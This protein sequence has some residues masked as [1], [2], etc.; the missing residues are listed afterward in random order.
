MNYFAYGSNLDMVQMAQRCPGAKLVGTAQLTGHRLCFPRRSPVRGCAVAS[1]E[2]HADEIVWGAI[3]DMS[4]DDFTRL[5]AREGYDPV[6]P[7]AINRYLRIDVS[8]QQT[9]GQTAKAITYVAVPDDTN[10]RPSAEYMRHIIEGAIVHGFPD[11]YIKMLRAI[12]TAED[13][14]PEAAA[15]RVAEQDEQSET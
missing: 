15:P 5:D 12:E 4:E 6:N 3:Y 14:Q 13:D 1:V 7:T 2:A 11:E 10:G 8:V 9:P